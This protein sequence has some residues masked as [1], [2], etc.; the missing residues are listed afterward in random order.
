MCLTILRREKILP[1]R[2][3]GNIYTRITN[4]TL[5]AFEE[6]RIAALE[7]ELGSSGSFCMAALTYTIL[8][9]AHAG[10]RSLQPPASTAVPLIIA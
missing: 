9:L 4:P 6:Q 2:K 1:L 8:A 10:D 3:P 7:V 5:S